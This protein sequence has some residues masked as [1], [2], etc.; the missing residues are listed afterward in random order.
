MDMDTDIDVGN[1]AGSD[2]TVEKLIAAGRVQECARMLEEQWACEEGSVGH[3][4]RR[5]G[6]WRS[7]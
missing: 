4:T 1:G 2:A 6:D 7:T 3:A 5:T